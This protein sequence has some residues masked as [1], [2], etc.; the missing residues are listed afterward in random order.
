MQDGIIGERTAVFTSATLQLGGSF[1]TIAEQLGLAKGSWVA[2]DVGSLSHT[3]LRRFC[4]SP[5]GCRRPDPIG[6]RRRLGLA[7]DLV[8]AAGGRALVLMASWNGVEAMAQHCRRGSGHVADSATWR[9]DGRAHPCLLRRAQQRADRNTGLWQ[10]VDVPGAACT[11][12]I[13]G[14]SPSPSQR[15]GRQCPP[16]RHRCPRRI[17]LDAGVPPQAAVTLAQG[18]G[19]LIR[20]NTD[21]GVVAILDSRLATGATAAICAEACRRSAS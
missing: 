9:T 4:S 10:G 15:S 18:A 16:S 21:R 2:S 13:I 19:R 14:N 1:D 8:A 6:P 12:V 11:L 7:A 17:W 3:N 20:S 5:I